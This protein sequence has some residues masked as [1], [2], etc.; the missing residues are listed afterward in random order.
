MDE[1]QR[2]SKIA[3]AGMAA[4]STRMRAISENLAN[5]D[6]LPRAADQL[7]YKRKVVTFKN[8]LDRQLGGETVKI[9]RITAD[10]AD[11]GKK[12]DPS[13][14]AADRD[15]YVLTPNVNPLIELM[16]MREAQRS[17]EANLQ[18]INMSKTMIQRTV[19]ML[20]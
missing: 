1:L 8:V 20:R 19:E 7:P 4:Q 9:N 15:G 5:A 16:D 14:P 17:Y 3:A 10:K 6:S 2:S 13:H 12:F 18:S 11:F